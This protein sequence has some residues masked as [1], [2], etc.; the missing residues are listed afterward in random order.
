M[1]CPTP[2]ADVVSRDSKRRLASRHAREKNRMRASQKDEKNLACS[3]PQSSHFKLNAGQA[4]E[5][6]RRA[7]TTNS[8]TRGTRRHSRSHGARPRRARPR[9][10]AMASESDPLRAVALEGRRGARSHEPLAREKNA[11]PPQLPDNALPPSA[12]P[13]PAQDARWP[14]CGTSSGTRTTRSGCPIRRRTPRSRVCCVTR[15]PESCGFSRK[16]RGRPRRHRAKMPRP[17]SNS[18][19]TRRTRSRISS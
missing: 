15:A 8:T 17:R 7:K 11:S 2:G 6:A 18:R 16:S 14:S 1:T 4:V 5:S 9:T 10:D 12:S 13:L 3:P 19:A